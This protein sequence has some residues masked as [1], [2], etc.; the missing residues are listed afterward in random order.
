MRSHS[1]SIG[2][3]FH[4]NVYACLRQVCAVG[5]CAGRTPPTHTSRR[6]GEHCVETGVGSRESHLVSKGLRFREL[7]VADCNALDVGNDAKNFRVGF[8]DAS[9]PQYGDA[10]FA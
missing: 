8:G 4:E 1:P 6:V 9:R 7:H 3:G 10:E 5:A 2:K